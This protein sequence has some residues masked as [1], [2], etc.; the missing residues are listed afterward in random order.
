MD[1]ETFYL[2][3]NSRK[4]TR[5]FTIFIFIV[6][7]TAYFTWRITVFNQDALLFS[8]IFFIAELFGLII[9]YTTLFVT[10]KVKERH[11]EIPPANFNVDIFIP[12]YNESP[13][14]VRLTALAA[15]N[16]RYP[17][18]TWILDD[19]NR[20]EIKKLADE[21]ECKYLS[22]KDNKHAKAGNLNNALKHSDAEFIAMFDADCT[23]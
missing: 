15:K 10:W 7:S 21:L 3:C 8:V 19:G 2:R 17:H 14:I 11:P 13:E 4:K 5:Y 12:T 20:I 23:G 1:I 18:H 9:T 16:I 6:F 22:R